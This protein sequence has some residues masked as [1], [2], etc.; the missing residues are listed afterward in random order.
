MKARESGFQGG[1]Y[2][3]VCCPALPDADIRKIKLDVIIG[4]HPGDELRF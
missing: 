2:R 1:T 3:R 4:E